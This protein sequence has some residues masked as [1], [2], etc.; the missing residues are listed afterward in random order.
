MSQLLVG[1]FFINLTILLNTAYFCLK[2]KLI[3]FQKL[4]I[5]PK[6]LMTLRLTHRR[7]ISH[8]PCCLAEKKIWKLLK[9]TV[10]K[11]RKEKKRKERK[12]EKERKK[13]QQTN[14]LGHNCLEHLV[15]ICCSHAM[16]FR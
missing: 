3:I 9:Q 15:L 7:F 10:E 13:H 6:V 4:F 5:F 12:K 14:Y 1:V 2:K 11:E 16:F 8:A